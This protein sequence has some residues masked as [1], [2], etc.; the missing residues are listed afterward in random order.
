M[1]R[2]LARVLPLP[3]SIVSVGRW[4]RNIFGTGLASFLIPTI[5]VFPTVSRSQ[6]ADQVHVEPRRLG[7][8][9]GGLDGP[10]VSGEPSLGV[11]TKPVRADVDL[12]L[13]PVTVTDALNRP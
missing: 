7:K 10:G 3:L 1:I 4:F 9:T 13:V 8:T 11:H 2:C 6:T 5:L 12:V